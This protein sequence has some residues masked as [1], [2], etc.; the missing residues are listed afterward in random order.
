MAAAVLATV[1]AAALPATAAVEGT[2]HQVVAVLPAAEVV[3]PAAAEAAIPV[4]AEAVTQVEAEAT[5]VGTAR[6]FARV[7][8]ASKPSIRRGWS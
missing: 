6:L 7:G 5:P 1:A 4:A 3:T 2:R 8:A